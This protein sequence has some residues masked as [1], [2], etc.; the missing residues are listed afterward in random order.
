MKIKFFK[1][2]SIIANSC[3]IYYAQTQNNWKLNKNQSIDSTDN[4][5]NTALILGLKLNFSPFISYFIL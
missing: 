3:N 2:F 5:G 1:I 4:N